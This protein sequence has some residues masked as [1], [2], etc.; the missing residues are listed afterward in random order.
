MSI[1]VVGRGSQVDDGHNFRKNL[2]VYMHKK[3][4]RYSIYIK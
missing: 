1:K 2:Q 3:L 4:P